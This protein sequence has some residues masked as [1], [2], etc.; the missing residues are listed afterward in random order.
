[1]KR[2]GKTGIWTLVLI[3]PTGKILACSEW[4]TNYEFTKQEWEALPIFNEKTD[5]LPNVVLNLPT[6]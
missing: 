1:M 5:S 4:G 3:Q 2:Q 6:D